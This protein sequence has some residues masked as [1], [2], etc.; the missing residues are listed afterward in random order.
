MKVTA[1]CTD[2]RTKAGKKMGAVVSRPLTPRE[3]TL[4]TQIFPVE[5][6]RACV[7]GFLIPGE[8]I[9]RARTNISAAPFPLSN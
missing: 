6:S 9:R 3:K 8:C 7:P 2:K 1:H 5:S 4:S